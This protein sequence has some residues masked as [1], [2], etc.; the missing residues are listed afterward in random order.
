M[1][2]FLGGNGQFFDRFR[3]LDCLNS[4]WIAE[5][6]I[7]GLWLDIRI[8]FE[9]WIFHHFACLGLIPVLRATFGSQF[10]STTPARAEDAGLDYQ[11]DYGDFPMASWLESI[12]FLPLL[13]QGIFTDIPEIQ[14]IAAAGFAR[15]SLAVTYFL[16]NWNG[17]LLQAFNAQENTKTPAWINIGVLWFMEISLAYLLAFTLKVGIFRDFYCNWLSVTLSIHS[18]PALFQ[19]RKMENDE[20]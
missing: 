14:A 12:Y 8:A 11:H 18:K 4:G 5:F 20:G 10:R 6:W 16:P 17:N 1:S 2:I 3:R 13:W 15:W 9:F 19:K 7:N